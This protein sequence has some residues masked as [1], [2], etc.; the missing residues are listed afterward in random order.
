METQTSINVAN[1]IRGLRNVSFSAPVFVQIGRRVYSAARY[2]EDRNGFD[3][4]RLYVLGRM[5]PLYEKMQRLCYRTDNSGYDWHIIA[6]F[7]QKA[8]CTEWSEVH[9]F[10]SHFILAQWSPVENW[11][12]DKVEKRPFHRLPMIITDCGPTEA[13]VKQPIDEEE[14]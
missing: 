6:W 4:T 11:A 1:W 10:G 2:I 9:K 12:A 13:D 8:G 5:P 14:N 3:E 7:R